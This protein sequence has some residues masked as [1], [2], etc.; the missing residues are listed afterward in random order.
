M[1]RC[2]SAIVPN[3]QMPRPSRSPLP[4][5]WLVSDARNDHGLEHALARLPR[6]SGLIYRHSHLAPADRRA[7]FEALARAARRFGHRVVLSGTARQAREWRADGAYGAA[8]K[9]APGPA[10]LRLVTVHSLREIA[11]GRRARADAVLLSP[12]FPTRSH[13]GAGTLGPVR[14]HLLAARSGVTVIALGGMTGHRARHL[15][16]RKWAAIQGLARSPTRVFPIH[17]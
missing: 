6:G 13:P 4:D 8:G 10:T 1:A 11:E 15:P 9:L 16:T 7:R 17:S 3:R 14:F 2:Y 5:I 12:V